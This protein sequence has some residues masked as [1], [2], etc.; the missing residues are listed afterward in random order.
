MRILIADSGATK[1]DWAFIQNGKPVYMKSSGLHPA[2]INRERVLNELNKIFSHTKPS[3]ILFY[4]AGCYSE[5]SSRPVK[6]LLN[7][8]FENASTEIYDDLTAVAH[9]FLGKEAGICAILGTGSAS[10]YF[11]GGKL[12][13]KVAPLGYILGDEGS[14]A[15]IGKRVLKAAFRQQLKNPVLDY[16]ESK[17][18]NL[19]YGDIISKLYDAKRPSF[20]LANISRKVLAGNIPIEISRIVEDS[21]QSFVEN[22]LKTYDTYR[23]FKMVFSGG[24][25]SH[26]SQ[27]LRQ[28]LEKNGITNYEVSG[29]VITALA[30]RKIEEMK[31]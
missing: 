31:G 7:D 12:K 23:E 10:G 25:A 5:E 6:G 29:G 18:D 30:E 19:D 26:Q 22:H 27:V 17:L 24:V 14:G 28:V 13:K 20:Y 8:L 2:Y 11:S 4:G 9:A 16:L 3:V 1:T 21:F 15:D